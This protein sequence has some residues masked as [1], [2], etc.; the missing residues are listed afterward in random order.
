[1]KTVSEKRAYH[2]LD[3][4]LLLMA[5]GLFV[6][7]GTANPGSWLGFPLLLMGLWELWMA[8]RPDPTSR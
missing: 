7:F 2:G 4:A 3:M 8:H 6:L 1:M 5:F